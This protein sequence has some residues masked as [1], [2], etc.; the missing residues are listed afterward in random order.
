M[1]KVELKNILTEKEKKF[2]DF[3]LIKNL[4]ISK[5]ELF[6]LEEINDNLISKIKKDLKKLSLWFPLEYYTKNANFYWSNFF[7]DNRV[8]IPRND[9]EI[10][11]QEALKIKDLQDFLI[12]DIWTWSSA[13]ICSIFK[14]IK[15]LKKWFALDISKKA[16]KITKKNIFF[17][18]LNKKI[19]FYKSNLLEIFFKKENFHILENKK[20]LVTANLPYI[21]NWDFENM[22]KET[23]I[24][25][26]KLALFWWEK[27]GFELYEK[28]IKQLQKLKILQKIKE[29]ILFIEIW[30]DQKEFAV[31]FLEKNWL[32][33][34]IFKDNS[35]INRCIK[36][37]F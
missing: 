27:T 20:I 18:K 9:T 3:S 36:V 11:V 33:Y 2:L 32:K 4:K 12:I 25:E 29:I 28:L 23:L 13:I 21:K 26:P 34:K 19:K 10:M 35:W 5:K 8:L 22:D 37:K 15:N 17:H 6:F 16:L 1:K 31:N 30:F 24:F 14:E 7:V